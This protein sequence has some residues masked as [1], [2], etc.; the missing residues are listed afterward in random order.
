MEKSN[1]RLYNLKSV[2]NK[3]RKLMFEWKSSTKID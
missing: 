1:N 3:L 2:W